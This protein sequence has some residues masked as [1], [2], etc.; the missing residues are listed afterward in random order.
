MIRANGHHTSP[1][2][3]GEIIMAQNTRDALRSKIFKTRKAKRQTLTLFEE[4]TEV[5]VRQPTIGDIMQAQSHEEGDER[6]FAVVQIMMRY[7]YVPGTDEK[8][9][10][11]ADLENIKD[12]P[13]GSWF[14]K[15]VEVF[16]DFVNADMG[17]TEKNSESAPTKQ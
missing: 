15:L 13:M 4:G 14:T 9:F 11:T 10:E 8:V 6:N 17:E 12:M 2:T 3:N 7:C 1:V 16:N 5:E